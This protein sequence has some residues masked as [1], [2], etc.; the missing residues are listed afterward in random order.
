MAAVNLTGR[1]K[2]EGDSAI[3]VVSLGTAVILAFLLVVTTYRPKRLSLTF[4][5]ESMSELQKFQ[6]PLIAPETCEQIP[7][8][9]Q[10]TTSQWGLSWASMPVY[11]LSRC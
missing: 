9:L 3:F 4:D 10:I 1:H 8:I 2:K 5:T 6:L 7:E 11:M